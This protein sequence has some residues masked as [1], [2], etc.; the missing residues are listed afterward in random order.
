M[1]IDSVAEFAALALGAAMP[2]AVPVIAAA[3]PILARSAK[4]AA[5]V[6]LD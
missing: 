1:L 5:N 6:A 3:T 2:E 4:G